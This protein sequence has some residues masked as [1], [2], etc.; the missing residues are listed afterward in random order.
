[1]NIEASGMANILRYTARYA[2]LVIGILVFLF[3]LFS[4]A[5]NY[6]NGIHGII[7]NSPN[8]LP[9]LVFLLVVFLAWKWELVGGI[10]ITSFG[11]FLIYFFNFLGPNFFL[12]TFIMTVL[13]TIL[14]SLFI[15]SWYLRKE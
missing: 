9:W 1:M 10:I 7:R 6:G 4:G 3:A 12:T 2:L 13:I 14:G 11:L 5:E 15:I 8:A